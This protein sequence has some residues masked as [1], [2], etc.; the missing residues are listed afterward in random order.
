MD[1][2]RVARFVFA[3][4]VLAVAGMVAAVP[5]AQAGQVTLKLATSQPP[6]GGFLGDT[7]GDGLTDGQEEIVGWIVVA[8]GDAPVDVHSNANA[9]DTD[10]DGLPDYAEFVLR[11][12]PNKAD[13]DGDGLSDLDELT[14][15]QLVSLDKFN[16]LFPNFVFNRTLNKEY[17]LVW[18]RIR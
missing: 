3:V 15:E 14:V 18:H 6:K 7:D 17:L 8:N 11:T 16:D 4:A 12:D 10:L 9:P 1:R 13:T 2:K 5:V